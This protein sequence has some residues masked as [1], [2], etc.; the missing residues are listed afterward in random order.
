MSGSLFDIL[1]EQLNVCFA[2]LI[3]AVEDPYW[4]TLLLGQLGSPT[5]N[6][7]TQALTT[8]LTS[9][10]NV[11]TEIET[12][13]AKSSPSFVDIQ[14]L[15]ENSRTA[16][17][18]IRSLDDP[19]QVTVGLEGMGKDLI[20]LLV[21]MYIAGSAPVLYRVLVL[22]CLVDAAE[23]IVPT[24]PVIAAGQAVRGP[25]ELPRFHFDRLIPLLHDP[26]T[27]LR[28]QYIINNL[29]T[30]TDAN[31]IADKIFPRLRGLLRV[32]G[33]LCKYG[34]RAEEAPFLGPIAPFVDHAL[35][36]WVQEQIAGATEDVGFIFAYLTSESWRPG[37]R[38]HAVRDRSL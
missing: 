15:L 38:D 27:F 22:L 30:D 31:A 37:A 5:D 32:L 13:A 34:L 6:S 25:V 12:L 23:D 20:D 17:A 1:G 2:P 29:A 26:A 19:Q 4:L 11:V 9:V 3:S 16:L 28:S 7:A 8:A 21:G 14:G 33:V 36:V 10:S 35:T 18:A 24:Q